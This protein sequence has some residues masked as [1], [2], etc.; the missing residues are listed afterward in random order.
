MFRHFV[1]DAAATDCIDSGIGFFH[2]HAVEDC[3]YGCFREALWAT[4]SGHREKIERDTDSGL[5]QDGF[6]KLGTS[7]KTSFGHHQGM[8]SG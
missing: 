8:T 6:E 2:G 5:V 4:F 7:I 3:A 1:R